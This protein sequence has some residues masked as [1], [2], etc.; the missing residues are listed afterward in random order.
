MQHDVKK[1]AAV[2][3]GKRLIAVDHR[4]LA[5]PFNLRAETS[6]AQI[7]HVVAT[8]IFRPPNLAN[9]K[10]KRQY[11]WKKDRKRA[12]L[13]TQQE[14]VRIGTAGSDLHQVDS[15]DGCDVIT[16]HPEVNLDLGEA[17]PIQGVCEAGFN[18]V[19]VS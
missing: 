16:P 18:F 13:P 19:M 8:N 15:N 1:V 9:M 6:M 2:H 4:A 12:R 11:T 17:W 7:K 14:A 10:R 5:R 3:P